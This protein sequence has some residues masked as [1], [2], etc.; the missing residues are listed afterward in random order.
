MLIYDAAIPR[1]ARP[2]GEIITAR[3]PH[4]RWD[5]RLVFNIFSQGCYIVYAPFVS[6]I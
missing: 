4:I 2:D 6:T 1:T 3:I 5:F